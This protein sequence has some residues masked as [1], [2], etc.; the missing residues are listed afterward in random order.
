MFEWMESAYTP[1]NDSGSEARGLRGGSWRVP[2]DV[3]ESW[4]RSGGFPTIETGD[5][6]FR[7]AAVSEPLESA[8]VI[9]L[10]ALGFAL[11]RRRGSLWNFVPFTRYPERAARRAIL[12]FV[13]PPPERSEGAGCSGAHGGAAL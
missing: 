13:R 10:A 2:A 1:P 9:G 4:F 3:P 11:W 7:V 5:L 6:G 12:G 8:G